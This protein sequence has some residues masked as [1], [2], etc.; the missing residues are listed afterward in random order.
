MSNAIAS[1]PSIADI[2]GL[3]GKTRP[4]HNRKMSSLEYC[5]ACP[6]CQCRDAF[7]AYPDM[8]YVEGIG[9]LGYFL[10]MDQSKGGRN[11][12]GRS[13]N[14]IDLVIH[15]DNASYQ[16]ACG[17][18]SIDQTVLRTDSKPPLLSLGNT[19]TTVISHWQIVARH[20]S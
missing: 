18:L 15:S 16:R 13:G 8:N 5:G 20:G 7:H 10:C 1:I 17:I 14:V 9:Y 3:S 4:Y 6:F 12:C 2:A 19:L 11:G